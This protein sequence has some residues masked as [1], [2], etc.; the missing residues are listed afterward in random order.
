MNS[1]PGM[2]ILFFC[3]VFLFASL[4][5]KRQAFTY[6]NFLL[7]FP[8]QEITATIRK[9][10]WLWFQGDEMDTKS[11]NLCGHWAIHQL[12]THSC[13]HQT[14]TCWEAAALLGPSPVSSHASPS[15]T[16]LAL[17]S[18]APPHPAQP[19]PAILYL[20]FTSRFLIAFSH[21]T[22]EPLFLMTLS[23]HDVVSIMQPAFSET[24][25]PL[26][27]KT[28]QR[29]S[30]ITAHGPWKIFI[31]ISGTIGKPAKPTFPKLW[32]LTLGSQQFGSHLFKG[33]LNVS[34]SSI[35]FLHFNL[36]FPPN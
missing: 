7:K 31:N 19:N 4:N 6:L 18:P 23:C 33:W 16:H 8:Q 28:V 11:W 26:F 36:V 25:L 35:F 9:N 27:I 22:Q 32:E 13:F 34:E 12:W 29:T 3:L 17:P 20:L 21:L 2:S 24:E 30:G 10:K 5:W 14:P 15:P 1:E